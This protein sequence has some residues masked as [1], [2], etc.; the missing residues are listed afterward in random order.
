MKLLKIL[1]FSKKKLGPLWWYSLII[2]CA[3]RLSD[4]LNILAGLWLVPK[5]VPE[6]ELGAVQPSRK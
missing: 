2:F 3:Q 1:D 5:Y 6:A 4:V